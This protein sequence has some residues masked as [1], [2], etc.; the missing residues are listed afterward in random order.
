[1]ARKPAKKAIALALGVGP[2]RV[3]HMIKA[4]MPVH[5]IEAAACWYRDNVRP[6]L[7]PKP[8][9]AQ[10]DPASGP[11]QELLQA[12]RQVATSWLQ[13]AAWLNAFYQAMNPDD[14]ETEAAF[15]RAASA[16]F[17]AAPGDLV[18]GMAE[19]DLAIIAEHDPGSPIGKA[20]R[21]ALESLT[22]A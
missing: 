10:G 5:S 11:D 13:Y 2:S 3:S 19:W 21:D 1:M 17:E 8:R 22:Q 14:P 16:A 20:A 7:N 12:F 6:R 9:K 4:G 18:Q 15:D